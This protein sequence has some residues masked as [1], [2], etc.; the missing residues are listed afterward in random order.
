LESA[1]YNYRKSIEDARLSYYKT[2]RIIDK[3]KIYEWEFLYYFIKGMQYI[4]Y[5]CKNLHIG[6][7]YM[8]LSELK[9]LGI[10]FSFNIKTDYI[11]S[12]EIITE[13]AKKKHILK[14]NEEIRL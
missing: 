1:C 11:I 12:E 9:F 8:L 7:F 3:V 10:Y 6:I 14:K 4:I 5:F 13:Y 2:N